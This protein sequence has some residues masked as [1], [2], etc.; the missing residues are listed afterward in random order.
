MA[1]ENPR[2]HIKHSK[3]KATPCPRA[4]GATTPLKQTTKHQRIDQNHKGLHKFE[5]R[6]SFSRW[7]SWQ[8]FWQISSSFQTNKQTILIPSNL[9]AVSCDLNW[10]E[11]E[12]WGNLL[13]YDIQ[14]QGSIC[15]KRLKWTKFQHPIHILHERMH[16]FSHQ[17]NLS[18]HL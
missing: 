9:L 11:G 5:H 8:I 4:E 18:T 2:S 14:S 13:L 1:K 15:H 3:E 17:R 6:S 16:F 12:I 10:K 7:F